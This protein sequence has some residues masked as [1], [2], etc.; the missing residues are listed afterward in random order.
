MWTLRIDQRYLLPLL[1]LLGQFGLP[2][3]SS[4]FKGEADVQRTCSDLPES[5][6][7]IQTML[8]V[9]KRGL[10]GPHLRAGAHRPYPNTTASIT[11]AKWQADATSTNPCQ[12][13]LW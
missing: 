9:L 10:A 3:K 7:W 1:A 8:P 11:A 2:S 13:A 12:M 5:D 6:P 4:G